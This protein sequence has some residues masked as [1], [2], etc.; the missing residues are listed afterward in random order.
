[1][2]ALPIIVLADDDEMH[3]IVAQRA[4]ARLMLRAEVIPVSSGS[5]ALRVLGIEPAGGIPAKRIAVVMLDIELPDLKGWQVLERIRQSPALRSVPVV[6]VTSSDRPEDVS[7]AYELGANSYLV[8]RHEPGRP[9][10][11]LARAARYW[12]E[13][14]Q[15]SQPAAET[16]GPPT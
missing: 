14:N 11:Y 9:G 13:L 3:L 12:V 15:A 16:L 6:L 8:K 1:M 2:S 10:D 7:R 5:E 4:I